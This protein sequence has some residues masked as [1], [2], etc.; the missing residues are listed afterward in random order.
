MVDL[1]AGACQVASALARKVGLR[2][3]VL[4]VDPSQEMLD[5]GRGLIRV[6]IQCSGALA[7]IS[8]MDEKSVHR[9]FIRQ[10]VHHFEHKRLR[11][12]FAGIL[13]M[14]KPGGR[15][16]ISKRGALE[17]MFPWPAG[18][19]EERCKEEIPIEV[20]REILREVGFKKFTIIRYLLLICG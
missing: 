20:L 16:C 9:I 10:A 4:C 1:G 11:D 14:L 15:L 17:E 6:K 5:T 3:P 18:F 13:R 19:Y 7:W 12:I 2:N 8:T